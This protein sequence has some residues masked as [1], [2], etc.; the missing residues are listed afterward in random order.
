M[1]FSTKYLFFQNA[2]IISIMGKQKVKVSKA[3]CQTSFQ[4]TWGLHLK[5]KSSLVWDIKFWNFN[6][7]HQ[8][9]FLSESFSG[10]WYSSAR[11]HLHESYRKCLLKAHPS[12][13]GRMG[14]RKM[15]QYQVVQDFTLH[16]WQKCPTCSIRQF[17]GKLV[18][19]VEWCKCRQQAALTGCCNS[20][21]GS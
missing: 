12:R 11:S 20:F 8:W 2:N 19:F 16:P 15:M 7:C 1:F 14:E 17:R 6:K 5:K 10:K 21:L 9:V 4:I 3:V 18:S 13:D